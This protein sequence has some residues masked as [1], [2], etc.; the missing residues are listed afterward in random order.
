ML[1]KKNWESAIY[2]AYGVTT[3]LDN[4]MWSGH[5]FPQGELIEAGKIIGPR[6]YTPVIRC[7]RA[8]AHGRT[9][10]PARG[11]GT[12]HRPPAILGGG[13]DKQYM[14]PRRDQRQWV[15]DARES[16]GCA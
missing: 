3:T 8:T 11:D 5:V 12:E 4:S 16:G 6:T 10:S 13:D 1:P 7:T 14:Q 15:S 2:M 9:S